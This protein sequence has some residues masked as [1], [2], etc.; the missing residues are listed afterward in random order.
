MRHE[1]RRDLWRPAPIAIVRDDEIN[2]VLL[3][4][5]LDLQMFLPYDFDKLW[6]LTYYF[7]YHALRPGIYRT[8][9]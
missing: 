1:D 4:Q 6:Y 3:D 9:C 5:L 7:P 8:V 2:F